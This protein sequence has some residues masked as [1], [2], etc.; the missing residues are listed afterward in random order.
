MANRN[1]ANRTPAATPAAALGT[2]GT[3]AATLAV[4]P[5]AHTGPAHKYGQSAAT[6]PCAAVQYK[7]TALGTLPG[8]GAKGGKPTAMAAVVAAA[9]IAG[10]S[11]T[12]PVSGMA[13]VQAM[14]TNA[15][16][17]AMLA[18]CRATKYV[19]RGVPCAAWC[20]GY[21]TGAARSQHGLLAKA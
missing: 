14:Q 2:P 11:T 10:A 18:Q 9:V 13:I 8:A 3:P 5:V 1:N 4:S 7:L 15:A 21:V 12:K 16:V 19:A 17:L 6:V 20:S